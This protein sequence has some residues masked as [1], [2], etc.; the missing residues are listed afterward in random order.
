M[1]RL[2][3]RPADARYHTPWKPDFTPYWP[4]ICSVN[5]ELGAEG[6]IEA[7]HANCDVFIYQTPEGPACWNAGFDADTRSDDEKAAFRNALVVSCRQRIEEARVLH[8]TTGAWIWPDEPKEGF[9]I[10]EIIP[11]RCFTDSFDR[12]SMS[13]LY[14]SMINELR[15][16]GNERR[17]RPGITRKCAGWLGYRTPKWIDHLTRCEY[18]FIDKD[19]QRLVT[20]A[21]SSALDVNLPAGANEAVRVLMESQA[22][23][24]A[25]PR[26]MEHSLARYMRHPTLEEEEADQRARAR[27]EEAAER[28]REAAAQRGVS[29][30]GPNSDWNPSG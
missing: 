25:I 2:R 28:H 16:I 19:A 14:L 8:D 26:D 12:Q 5:N 3:I 11:I 24:G 9:S 13:F 30:R 4:R 23:Q 27:R 7:P 6:F 20:R 29:K 1:E 17:A 18:A 10:D 15:D 22:A 21:I